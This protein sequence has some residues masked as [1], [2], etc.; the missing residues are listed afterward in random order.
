MSRLL[1]EAVDLS[2]KRLLVSTLG[3]EC[4]E[5]LLQ[6]ELDM[7]DLLSGTA[8]RLQR[9]SVI[10]EPRYLKITNKIHNE[11]VRSICLRHPEHLMDAHCILGKRGMYK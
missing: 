1:V 10:K 8:R 6:T 5:C 11:F 9:K 3:F 7:V 4:L 2:Q